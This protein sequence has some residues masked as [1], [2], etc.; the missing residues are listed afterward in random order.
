M[1][2]GGTTSGNGGAA[3]PSIEKYSP[4]KLGSSS[5]HINR[6]IFTTSSS[7]AYRTD[8]LGKSYPYAV[9]SSPRHPAPMPSMKRFSENTWRVAAILAV[10]AGGR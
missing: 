2:T 4:V 10:S 5:V 8:G 6:Q 1:H 7:C 9:Y 3:A